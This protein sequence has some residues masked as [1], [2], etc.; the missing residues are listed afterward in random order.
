MRVLE[1]F[2][3]RLI[4]PLSVMSCGPIALATDM[5]GH[6]FAHCD[7]IAYETCFYVPCSHFRDRFAP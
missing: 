5:K 4:A 2:K 3:S 7:F 6:V 1:V